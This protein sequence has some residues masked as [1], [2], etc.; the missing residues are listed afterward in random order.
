MLQV[1]RLSLN[2]GLLS[3]G[4]AAV[5]THILLNRYEPLAM[6]IL[7]LFFAILP[8]VLSQ[9]LIP[10]FT[11]PSAVAFGF[12]LYH[13]VLLTSVALY[14]VSPVHPLARYPGPIKLK[15]ASYFSYKLSISGKRHL[16]IQRL[17]QDYDSDVVRIGPNEISIRDG[18]CITTILGSNGLSKGPG[19]D[20]RGFFLSNRS[21]LNWR[22]PA[23]HAQRRKPWL[24]GLNTAAMKHY[25]PVLAARITQLSDILLR[26]RSEPIDLTQFI[27]HFSFDFMGDMAFGGGPELMKD[28]DT[29]GLMRRME[30][31][32]KSGLLVE[33]FPW[34][35]FHALKIPSIKARIR[36]FRASSDARAR[37]RILKGTQVKDLFHFLNNDDGA[38]PVSPSI[39]DVAAEGSLV[40]L[41]GSDTVSSTLTALM[42]RLMRHPDVYKKL[43]AEVDKFYPPGESALDCKYHAKMTYL[44]AVINETLRLYPAQPSGSQRAT[45]D[46]TLVAGTH[47]IPPYTSVRVHVYSIHRD[48]RNFSPSPETFWP[49]RWLI[50]SNP[51]AWD[52]QL[53]KTP[54][55]HNTNAFIPFSYGPANCVGKNLAMMEL[56]MVVC[57][58]L[59]QMDFK[60]AKPDEDHFDEATKDWFGLQ[61]GSLPV[62]ITPRLPV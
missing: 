34:F 5:L 31:G 4:V 39:D 19:Y 14:R 53:K 38:E 24:R 55:V 37:Q 3:I 15:L 6:H 16:Y 43:R 57:H 17:H 44:E 8:L 29:H 56:R 22:D 7:V 21:L 52:S 28:G 49:E 35:A 2:D 10:H 42:Y 62:E 36:A 23:K 47:Y 33:A 32:I 46:A 18:S 41:A 48:P 27:T 59:Q 9:L 13:L 11:T 25:E 58:L 1:L 45:T 54:F 50:A 20:G 61:V 60:L 12:T 26:K 51:S 40:V 30:A